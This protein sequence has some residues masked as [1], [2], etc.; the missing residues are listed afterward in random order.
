MTTKSKKS[1]LNPLM[2]SSVEAFRHQLEVEMGDGT[3]RPQYLGLSPRHSLRVPIL[4]VLAATTVPVDAVELRRIVLSRAGLDV[5]SAR[6]VNLHAWALK[7]L[8]ESGFVCSE[9][10]NGKKVYGLRSDLRTMILVFDMLQNHDRL[11]E[12]VEAPKAARKPS[13]P[14]SEAVRKPAPA[15]SVSARK[16]WA[17][18]RSR[19]RAAATETA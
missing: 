17:T 4:R 10:L 8:I 12:A 19:E 14:C 6:I 11:S 3:S 18:R 16:A 7:D 1:N 2:W 15:R 9:K 5:H 13:S